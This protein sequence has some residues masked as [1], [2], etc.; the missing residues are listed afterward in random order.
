MRTR[1]KGIGALVILALVV[2]AC[3]AGKPLGIAVE[4]V[5]VQNRLV[6]AVAIEFIRL[7]RTGKISDVVYAQGKGAYESYAAGEAA[8]AKSLA[9]WKRIG[10]ADS[11]QRLSVALQQFQEL[12]R[13]YLNFIGQFVDVGAIRASLGGK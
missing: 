3:A 7:H 11:S 6:K 4:I 12:F 8:L 13:V 2:S 10:D 5:D 9:D 1:T